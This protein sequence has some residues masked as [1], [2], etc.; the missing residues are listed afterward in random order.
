M[1]W[2]S[3]N[4]RFWPKADVHSSNNHPSHQ[5]AENH[6]NLL[7][8]QGGNPDNSDKPLIPPHMG[9]V[10]GSGGQADCHQIAYIIALS[11]IGLA[12]MESDMKKL[13]LVFLA[14]IAFASLA[15]LPFV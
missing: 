15:I 11:I 6:T 5:V 8:R 9:Q 13:L 7:T 14:V 2:K 3:L 12:T 10:I 4:S 1:I